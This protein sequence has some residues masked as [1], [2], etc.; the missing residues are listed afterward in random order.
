MFI[1]DH[2]EVNAPF[3]AV[4]DA[5]ESLGAEVEL[6]AQA[7]YERGERLAVGPGSG[8]MA[9]PVAFEVGRPLVSEDGVAIPIAW[10]GASGTNLLPRMD[11]ELEATRMG[12]CSTNLLFR[13]RYS[14]PLDSIGEA[15]DRVLL[16]HVAQATV[17]AF[18]RR[19]GRALETEVG[20]SSR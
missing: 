19:L 12:T 3:E 17:G 16:H 1:H 8:F 4:V 13:G 15:L 11:A 20:S 2:I 10:T 7:A 5:L 9:A 18:M 6:M 14:P